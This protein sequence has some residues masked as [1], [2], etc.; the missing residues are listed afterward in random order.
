MDIRVIP[1]I[2]RQLKNIA[3]REFI[4]LWYLIRKNDAEM[5]QRCLIFG[6][7]CNTFASLF[8]EWPITY[9]FLWYCHFYNSRVSLSVVQLIMQPHE[10]NSKRYEPANRYLVKSLW[11]SGVEEIVHNINGFS[12]MHFG[13]VP[14]ITIIPHCTVRFHK[15]RGRATF[16][17]QKSLT[18]LVG[19]VYFMKLVLLNRMTISAISEILKALDPVIT[20]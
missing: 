16:C 19:L 11:L 12:K 10:N 5:Y 14:K 20:Q 8:L 4:L 7:F 9:I 15:R 18:G 17:M 1:K 6:P 2:M 3:C 13:M